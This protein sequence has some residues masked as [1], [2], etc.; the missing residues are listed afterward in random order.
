[1]APNIT[2]A[3]VANLFKD[4][5]NPNNPGESIESAEEP[6]ES[7]LTPHDV[8]ALFDENKIAEQGSASGE[9][10]N[11]GDYTDLGILEATGKGLQRGAVGGFKAVGSVL[12]RG[13]DY[14]TGEASP[15]EDAK[16][17]GSAVASDPLGA[18]DALARTGAVIGS[19]IEGGAVG[20]A[21]GSVVPFVGTAAGG[22]IGAFAGPGI[23]TRLF[24]YLDSLTGKEVPEDNLS[25]VAGE[26]GETIGGALAGAAAGKALRAVGSGLKGVGR[27]AANRATQVSTA[28]EGETALRLTMARHGAGVG[29]KDLE[30]AIENTYPSF[31]R[32]GAILKQQG[33]I[34]TVTQE[35]TVFDTIDK[36]IHAENKNSG[37]S[38]LDDVGRKVNKAI[39]AVKKRY[40]VDE[41][42][43]IFNSA[44]EK[45][46]GEEINTYR[47]LKSR[48]MEPFLVKAG[49]EAGYNVAEVRSVLAAKRALPEVEKE[50]IS[51][52]T[53][54]DDLSNRIALGKLPDTDPSRLVADQKISS[55]AALKARRDGLVK[56]IG[57]FD[58]A[59]ADVRLTPNQ[60][61]DATNKA[62]NINWSRLKGSRAGTATTE[63]SIMAEFRQRVKD[64]FRK[65]LSSQ[66]LP[67]YEAADKEYSGLKVL[68]G[69]AKA[70]KE[71]E[72]G[73]VRD[74]SNLVSKAFRGI[75]RAILD[76][77]GQQHAAIDHFEAVDRAFDGDTPGPDFFENLYKFLGKGGLPKAGRAADSVSGF[78]NPVDAAIF[79]RSLLATEQYMQMHPEEMAKER[80]QIVGSIPRFKNATEKLVT[81]TYQGI[82][83]DENTQRSIMKDLAKDP[84]VKPFLYM[85][86]QRGFL[87]G[88]D[89]YNGEPLSKADEDRYF[90]NLATS[91]LNAF[92]KAKRRRFYNEKGR[93]MVESPDPPQKTVDEADLEK[94]IQ[95][96]K[97]RSEIKKF[98]SAKDVVDF[99]STP[100]TEA[101]PELSSFSPDDTSF[102]K[103]FNLVLANEG[104][105]SD[106]PEDSGGRTN[107]GITQKTYS[108]YL[109]K[110]GKKFKDVANIS[111]G[112]KE[113][114]YKEY[115]SES[116]AD[117]LP[118]PLS[119]IVFDSAINSGPKVAKKQLQ[120]VLGVTEDGIIGEETLGA[121]EDKNLSS[122]AH[123]LLDERSRFYKSLDKPKFSRGWENRVK[124]LR[125]AI[126]GRVKGVVAA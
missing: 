55:L 97:A 26:F 75:K 13:A 90:A 24:H 108:R 80:T 87:D 98:R 104:G 1:M 86:E 67:L 53:T 30:K 96:E 99:G 21:A 114:I 2:P 93:F 9:K 94:K 17:V 117:T 73:T 47:G 46:A 63:D 49:K 41:V 106:D 91:N 8:A 70:T 15:I 31:V 120:K 18:V 7:N 48:S 56:Q 111:E 81:S 35:G 38:L 59:I 60:V 39:A 3:D 110:N 65:G 25:Q 85:D 4:E 50:I 123:M 11:E 84:D 102:Q 72:F 116:G 115:W 32:Q 45:R 124:K 82:G 33:Q 71:S 125:S 14:L 10:I 107:F 101:K 20:A 74:P 95:M 105:F 119:L 22:V 51:L 19:A 126:G 36:V 5:E 42:E 83:Q 100:S 112:E 61:W 122:V 12:G 44:R 28:R 29:E 79:T 68:S 6:G 43:G 57:D 121:L 77:R 40:S 54:V 76:P 52:T 69:L 78:F 37:T 118:W 88:V 92:E 113:E 16:A 23:V 64:S 66:D 103:A 62:E 109:V 58:S 89:S 27:A 34:P